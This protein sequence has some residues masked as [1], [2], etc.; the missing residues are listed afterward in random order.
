MPERGIGWVEV[1][2]P[3]RKE[4]LHEQRRPSRGLVH[5]GEWKHES[6]PGSFEILQEQHREA[7]FA[8]SSRMRS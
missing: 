6:F 5:W 1:T 3:R 7:C 4:G 2:L 8:N